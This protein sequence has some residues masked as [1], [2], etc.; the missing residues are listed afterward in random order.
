MVCGKV[1]A[2]MVIHACW[3][4]SM[5]HAVECVG[6]S[7][8]Q[9]LQLVP[10]SLLSSF[11]TSRA[12][13]SRD[14]EAVEYILCI[15]FPYTHSQ[16]SWMACSL[17]FVVV[18]AFAVIFQQYSDHYAI[19][20]AHKR[21]LECLYPCSTKS[22]S[23]QRE[24]LGTKVDNASWWQGCHGRKM[25]VVNGVLCS[26]RATTYMKPGRTEGGAGEP[27]NTVGGSS[28]LIWSFI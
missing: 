7:H 17:C 18:L 20:T 27:F 24:L 16:I 19:Q 5:V 2:A 21:K 28:T 1:L 8:L 26:D 3:C 11:Q 4:R 14:T 22:S 23:S 6:N 25:W 10:S 9:L 15:H 12:S 13:P